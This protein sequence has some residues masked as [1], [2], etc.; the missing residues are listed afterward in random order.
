MKK[1]A[2]EAGLDDNELKDKRINNQQHYKVNL[3][4]TSGKLN[5]LISAFREQDAVV[6]HKVRKGR[7]LPVIDLSQF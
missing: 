4:Q 2:N 3:I 6:N 7:E 1:A 5:K